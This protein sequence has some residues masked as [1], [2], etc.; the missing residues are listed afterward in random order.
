M[1]TD[2]RT[3][4]FN[5][6]TIA[7]LVATVCLICFYGLIAFNVISHPFAP[8]PPPTLIVLPTPTDTPT[9]GIPT[10][11]PT[12]TPTITPTPRPTN[13]RT[14][15]LTPSNTPTFPPTSTPTL[16]PTP[17]PR[18]TRSLWPFTYETNL[19]SPPYGCNWTGVA[20][21]VQ[22]LDGNP[23]VGYPVH[24]WGGGIDVVVTSGADTRFN[25]IYGSQAAWEQF[26]DN[27]PKPIQIRVQIHDPYR[28]D[29]PPVSDEIVLDMPGYCG[30]ALGFIVFTQ[31]H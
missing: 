24:V 26:F 13:T 10:W 25:T 20:G 5:V 22:D 11:T 1:E 31:N 18:V 17:T 15:T 8:P 12:N 7:V 21:Y 9:P 23:L 3:R 27:K 16:S 30:G 28:S 14:P 29:H 19:D 6:L 2:R 4:P